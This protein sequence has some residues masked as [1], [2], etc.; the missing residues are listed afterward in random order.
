M[1][2]FKIT[3]ALLLVQS[4]VFSQSKAVFPK[5]QNEFVVIAHRGYHGDVPE[6]TVESLRKAIELGV[7]YV[8]VDVRTTLEG[9]P[10]VMHD[11][12]LERTT[13]G[14]GRVS[15]ISTIDFRELKIKGTSIAPP[16]LST[17]LMEARG[18]I[19][20]YL[21]IKDADPAKIVALLEK[22]QMKNNV[23]VYCITPQ[24][25]QWKKLAPT[26]PIIVSPPVNISTAFEFE[27]FLLSFP[28]SI[29]DGTIKMYNKVISQK[30]IEINTPIWLDTLDGDDNEEVWQAAIDLGI[31]A[32]QT[33]KPKALMEFLQKNKLRQ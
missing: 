32:L 25:L 13:N 29:L 4:L 8:E 27:A 15:E 17:I 6:N 26:I 7:D 9:V 18:K 23:V 5:T 14:K 31:K 16:T 10:V 33:N 3:T 2:I 24:V 22:Y 19:N 21:D 1:K 12:T 11:A 28:A 30:L 20:L